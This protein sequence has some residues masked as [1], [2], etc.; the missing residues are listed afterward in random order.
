MKCSL[1]KWKMQTPAQAENA[2]FGLGCAWRAKMVPYSRKFTL[3]M[4]VCGVV[5][6][7]AA[8]SSSSRSRRCGYFRVDW[9]WRQAHKRRGKSIHA[10]REERKIERHRES[11][12]LSSHNARARETIQNQNRGIG[13]FVC[14]TAPKHSIHYSLFDVVRS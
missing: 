12:A 1:R 4:V 8:T 11:E 14:K 5:Q 9:I 13:I 3:G 7:A 6:F 2:V 10:H